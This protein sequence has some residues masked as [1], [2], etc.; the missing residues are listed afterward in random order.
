VGSLCLRIIQHVGGGVVGPFTSSW[1]S[2]TV[3]VIKEAM[4]QH[5]KRASHWLGFPSG[6][7]PL[8][9]H[10]IKLP[11]TLP[12][13]P[14]QFTSAHRRLQKYSNSALKCQLAWS[15]TRF[16]TPSTPLHPQS[17]IKSWINDYIINDGLLRLPKGTCRCIKDPADS[18]TPSLLGYDA[19]RR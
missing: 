8:S 19:T 13:V 5:T 14:M 11:S 16:L 9:P 10:S 7:I 18:S 15:S 12:A 3:V 1:G 2:L 6:D 17:S 4:Q